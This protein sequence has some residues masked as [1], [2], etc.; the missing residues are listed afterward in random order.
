[1][2]SVC[3]IAVLCLAATAAA[4]VATPDA[5]QAVRPP[6]PNP[7]RFAAEIRAFG[8]WDTKNSSPP[9]AILFTGSSTIRLWPTSQSFPELTVINRG[10]GGAHI[11]DVVHYL[12]QVVFKYR[13]RTIVFYAGDNDIADGKSPEQVVDDFKTFVRQVR[14]KLPETR[15]IFLGIKP[16]VARWRLWPEMQRAN[17][18]VREMADADAKLDF[19]D[20]APALLGEDGQPRASFLV[21]D[22]LHM[23]EEGY[24]AWTRAVAPA[25]ANT[26]GPH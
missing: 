15:V 2:H 23:N 18:M 26:A 5:P 12:D 24:Q 6:N 1:M 13:P 11:S 14:E 22:G 19:V 4:Q 25:L 21:A 3:G 9:D 17:A 16:S 20:T 8:T 7:Q 10:F